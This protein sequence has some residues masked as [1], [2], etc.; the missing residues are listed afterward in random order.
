MTELHVLVVM[1]PASLRDEVVD[2]LIGLE[3]VTGFTLFEVAGYGREHSHFNLQERVA[4]YRV[5][6]RF[7]VLH[8]VAHREALYRALAG[9]SG[10][11]ALRYWVTPVLEEGYLGGPGGG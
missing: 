1:V 11:E 10:R 8:E 5:M 3:V 6:F 7:E 9:A 2:A 4:G